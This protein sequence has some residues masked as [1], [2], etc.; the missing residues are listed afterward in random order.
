MSRSANLFHGKKG[1]EARVLIGPYEKIVAERIE[2]R[3][4]LLHWHAFLSRSAS[5][6]AIGRSG[7]LHKYVSSQL[8]PPGRKSSSGD[9]DSLVGEGMLFLLG[10]VK[11]RLIS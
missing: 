11:G 1:S 5:T 9:M 8:D 7:L 4:I 6:R 3:S 10:S 2:P